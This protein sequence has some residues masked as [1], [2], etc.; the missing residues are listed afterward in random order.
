MRFYPIHPYPIEESKNG[1]LNICGYLYINAG[2]QLPRA[3]Q[4]INARVKNVTIEGNTF[5]GYEEDAAARV[6]IGGELFINN[7]D[8]NHAIQSNRSGFAVEDSDYMLIQNYMR[9]RIGEVVSIVRQN[10]NIDSTVKRVL[11]HVDKLRDVF[12]GNA[13]VEDEKTDAENFKEL[14]DESVSVEGLEPYKLDDKLRYEL[15]KYNVDFDFTWSGTLE[16]LLYRIEDEEDDYYTI[17][18]N[19]RLKEFLFDVAGNAVEYYVGYCGEDR[20]LIIK[21]TGKLII[22]LDNVLIP[23]RDIT[24]VDIGFIKVVIILYLNYLRCGN[25]AEALYAKSIE[26]LASAR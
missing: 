22:N 25:N 7:I 26:D 21:K 23:N 5:F 18:V 1:R 17:F 4:G 19:E 14:D 8:E 11:Q 24:K 20:P 10:T 9:D 2:K 12:E 6:R 16:D 13:A 15:E 3:W